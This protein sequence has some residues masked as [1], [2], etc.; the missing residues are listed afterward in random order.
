VS[1]EFSDFKPCADAQSDILHT[2]YAAKTDAYGFFFG[3][4]VGLGLGKEK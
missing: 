4:L 1:S 2:K 3:E